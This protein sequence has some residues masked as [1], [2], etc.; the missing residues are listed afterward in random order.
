M[1]LLFHLKMNSSISEKFYLHSSITLYLT[2]LLVIIMALVCTLIESGRVSAM[3]AS[4]RSITYMAADS[5]FSEFAQPIFDRYG[6]ML[7]WMD[8]EEY[9]KRFS[10]YIAENLNLEG[11]GAGQDLE[12]Y[13]MKYESSE[14]QSVTWVT[15]QN[16]KAFEDQVTEYMKVHLVEDIA[17][18]L[19]SRT[20]YFEQTE[21]ARTILGKLSSYQTELVKVEK[22]VVEISE[23]TEQIKDMAEN[24]KTLLEQLGLSLEQYAD[25]DRDAA[26]SFQQNRQE[27]ENTKDQMSRQLAEL[28][29]KTEQYAQ[30][31]EETRAA[32]GQMTE[33]LDVN[34]ADFDPEIYAA[35]R[36]QIE[37]LGSAGGES[38]ADYS[39]IEANSGIVRSYLDQLEGL[40]GYFAGTGAELTDENLQQYR[41]LTAQYQEQFSGQGLSALTTIDAETAEIGELKS[42]AF[43]QKVNDTYQTGLLDLLAGEI[44]E[45]A[46]DTAEFP[47]QTFQ[48][49]KVEEEESAVDKTTQKA[50]FCAYITE[51][52]GNFRNRKEGTVLDYEAEYI[53]G[54]KD[55][56][57]DNLSSAVTKIVLLRSGANLI[58]LMMDAAKKAEI[59]ELALAVTA[60]IHP[61]VV[62]IAE[63][64][65]TVVWAL[66]EAILDMKA[67]LDG[68][69][70]AILKKEGDWNL[71]I[72]GLQNFTGEE[73]SENNDP[74]GLGYE[75]YLKILLMLENRQQQTFRTMDLIQANMAAS[76]NPGFRVKDCI[77]AVESTATFTANTVFVSLPAIRQTMHT[78]AGTYQFSFSQNYSY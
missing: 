37:E 12:L 27:L 20:D 39:T 3:N 2:L 7:L 55:N 6:V 45:K 32:V 47:S 1:K 66:A 42:G 24:P 48:K 29:E 68:K 78:P 77:T 63:V 58:S 18:E 67:L 71:S 49:E 51:H 59:K 56:D 43:I 33:E 41:E 73:T 54:G 69:K 75:D 31:V 25:G 4:L 21:K 10:S 15:D 8:E 52:F 57:R 40:E 44:S 23:K 38:G 60:S 50:L 14:V 26:A 76:E 16:G 62:K 11:T 5:V 19:L 28:Q 61:V 22:G 53:L 74:T 17:E 13:G 70:I 72:E 36:N 46:V 30:N 65:I 34:E 35:I 64:V 9:Q